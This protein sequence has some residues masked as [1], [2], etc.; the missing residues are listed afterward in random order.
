MY[1][2]TLDAAILAK[3]P[4]A[5]MDATH[6]AFERAYRAVVA[7]AKAD[8]D[9]MLARLSAGAG[10]ENGQN[11]GQNNGQEND[12]N[13]GQKNGQDSGQENGQYQRPGKRSGR[14]RGRRVEGASQ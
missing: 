10:P 5:E 12:Q 4:V 9:A 8:A 2:S 11:I 7:H 3:P 1:F 13:K 14:G 6:A